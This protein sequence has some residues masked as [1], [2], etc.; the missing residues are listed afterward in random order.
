[1]DA[2]TFSLN[3][4]FPISNVFRAMLVGLNVDVINCRNTVT[5]VPIS[6]G[7]SIYAYGGPILYLIVQ[8]CF[9]LWLLVWLESV[10]T[11]P[12]HIR[13]L[14]KQTEKDHIATTEKVK[15]EETRVESV[16]SDL[17]RILR[18]TKSFGQNV[19]V[20]D[21]SFGIGKGEIFALLGPNGAGKST[22]VNMIG[23]ILIPDEG[24]IM[25]KGTDIVRN[26]RAGQKY[27]GGSVDVSSCE[28][29]ILI[30]SVYPQFDAFDLMTVREYLEFYARAKGVLT[31]ARDVDIVIK[32]IGLQDYE[33]RFAA[34][35][36]GGNKRKL[37]LA[38]ALIGNPSIMLLDEPS[39]SL[40]AVSKRFMWKTLAEVSVGR[41]MLLTTHSM[42]EAA[43]I[44]TR[45]AIMARRI[46]TVGTTSFLRHKYGDA[47]HVH[48]I[49]KPAPSS[50]PQEMQ[51]V[52]GWVIKSFKGAKLDPFGSHQGQIKFEVPASSKDRGNISH[53]EKATS[54][55]DII[56]V[57]G[58]AGPSKS[59]QPGYAQRNVVAELFRVLEK[60]KDEIGLEYYS[61]SATTLNDVFLNVVRENNVREE[62][63]EQMR[64]KRNFI[65]V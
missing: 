52:E 4:F 16:D 36:S 14:R 42:E 33:D 62:G 38:I 3:L 65:W 26:I 5:N 37:S 10:H 31:V 24:S 18:L 11:I 61:V 55:E 13:R 9:Y 58:L 39:S 49:L 7:G 59:V 45:A 35:L 56:A 15:D 63:S 43:A 27:L 41:S 12:G 34:K 30:I 29:E 44:A 22:I 8:V 64:K 17:L 57:A 1:M 48:M 51:I 19:A 40:D 54:E 21:V 50:S 20:E 60:S 32:K 47:Y 46:L 53:N 6:H 2:T 25:L 28:K 23:G